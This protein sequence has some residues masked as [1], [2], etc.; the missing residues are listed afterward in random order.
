MLNES[1]VSLAEAAKL[2]PAFHGRK[3]HSS[4][5]WR[6]SRVGVRGVHLRTFFL[7]SR[8]CTSKEA[9]AEFSEKLS[10]LPLLPRGPRGPRTKPSAH[11]GRTGAQRARDLA[12]AE[13]RLAEAGA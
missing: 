6:W 1:L 8:L 12:D 11:R 2:L 9:L 13:R 10:A 3:V 4:T 5:L 7:G